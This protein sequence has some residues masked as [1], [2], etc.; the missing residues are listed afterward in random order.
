MLNG[1]FMII[2]LIAGLL[3]QIDC[4]ICQYFP[5]PYNHFDWLVK[6][7]LNLSN[8]ATKSDVKKTKKNKS[9]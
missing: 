2:Y 4:K 8:Y 1:N 9:C 3:S 7:E 6:V 5:E